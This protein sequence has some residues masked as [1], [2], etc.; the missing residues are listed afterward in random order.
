MWINSITDLSGSAPLQPVGG[1]DR[2]QR[3][4]PSPISRDRP[5]CS[6]LA[7]AVVTT[8]PGPSPIS[9]DRPHC[10]VFLG[11]VVPGVVAHHRSLGIGPI[12]A[13]GL[14]CLRGRAAPIT[15]LSGSAP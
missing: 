7:R 3:V 11:A 6:G 8:M 1:A 12:A 14:Q 2:V 13:D 10:S 9:R 15:D 4:G 5:H